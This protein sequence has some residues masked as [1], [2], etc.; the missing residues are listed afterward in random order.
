M[1]FNIEYAYTSNIGKIRKNH[2]DNFWC[3][4]DF[5]PAINSGTEGVTSGII[6]SEDI[7]AFGVF[8]GMGGE[9][10]GE[11]ASAAAAEAF[12]AYYQE[13]KNN[14]TEDP[15]TFLMELGKAMNDRV[16]GY[17][18]D[19]NILSMGSTSAVVL[20]G[21]DWYAAS[22]IGDSRI[23]TCRKGKLEQI[24]TDH[25]FK[26]AGF[27]KAPL[28][29]YLG[30]EEADGILE[31]SYE[32]GSLESGLRILICSDG[33]T[34]MITDEEL[35]DLLSSGEE[36]AAVAGTILE[37][38]LENGGRDNITLILLQA[39]PAEENEKQG[40]FSRVFGILFG[41]RDRS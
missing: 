24:S 8:D 17:A 40:F 14:F 26:G 28:V 9:S 16:C 4:G 41:G 2:E 31:P 22:N 30:L 25:V 12:D 7:P 6:K 1:V 35:C 5:L 32:R 33:V 21:K 11:M 34:D 19:N 39:V 18:A 29:Q 10:C 38:A 37:K 20:F 13:N 3:D 15:R 23:Y 36:I 27:R